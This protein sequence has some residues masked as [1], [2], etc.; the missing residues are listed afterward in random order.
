MPG[1]ASPGLGPSAADTRP[2]VQHEALEPGTQIQ[3][4]L[5]SKT[6]YSKPVYPRHWIQGMGVQRM[7][8]QDVSTLFNMLKTVIAYCYIQCRPRR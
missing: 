5:K 1:V 3:Y 4:Y 8:S 2:C 7:A 6:L